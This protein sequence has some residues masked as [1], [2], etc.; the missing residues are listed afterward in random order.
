MM[1]DTTV[2]GY[3]GDGEVI[4]PGCMDDTTVPDGEDGPV[5]MSPLYSL[6]DTSEDGLSC[7]ACGRYIF[8][9]DVRGQAIAAIEDLLY[10]PAE[11]DRYT[12]AS[13]ILSMLEDSYG[14][15]LG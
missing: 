6:D 11:M 5:G 7:D 4:C 3:V 14:L 2:Y 1:V 10:W 13:R 12:R 15:V 9:P 8:E